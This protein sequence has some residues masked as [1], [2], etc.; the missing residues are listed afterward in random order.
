MRE[1]AERRG[2]TVAIIVEDVGSGV[3]D[4]PTCPYLGTGIHIALQVGQLQIGDRECP[5]DVAEQMLEVK[6]DALDGAGLEGRPVRV[7]ITVA[8]GEERQDA[9]FANRHALHR[10]LAVVL[11][12]LDDPY[13]GRRLDQPMLEPQEQVIDLGRFGTSLIFG[14]GPD[15]EG[16][17]LAVVE[18]LAVP[19]VA[20]LLER[21][22]WL[23]LSGNVTP[24]SAQRVQKKCRRSSF[25]T[26][27][28]SS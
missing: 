5:P 12:I 18:E 21:C 1:H 15:G 6:L 11:D 3:L 10:R 7:E 19:T 27:C 13:S 2:W 16:V 26:F 25:C 14:H 23:P 9:L 20:L 17:P 8:K 24:I 4:G 28:D 22:H